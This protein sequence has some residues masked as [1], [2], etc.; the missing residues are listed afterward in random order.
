M[1]PHARGS[2]CRALPPLKAGLF[3]DAWRT[4]GP[5][6]LSALRGGEWGAAPRLR[7]VVWRVAVPLAGD[8]VDAAAP[9]A[10]RAV[11]ELALGAPGARGD[12]SASSSAGAAAAAGAG[13]PRRVVFEATHA[14]LG[15]LFDD[16]ERIQ[17]Q[18]DALS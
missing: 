16:V 3:R 5:A 15:A 11:F 17:A 13:A 2:R 10:Q 4:H 1:S 8:G 9:P 6:L 12:A 14:Q 7:S 18:L